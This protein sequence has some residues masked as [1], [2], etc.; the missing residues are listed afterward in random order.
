MVKSLHTEE[1]NHGPAQLFQMTGFGRLG[2]PS[3]G[4]W[5]VYGLGTENS[6]LP[7]FVVMNTGRVAG[8][9]RALWGSGFL[10]GK[11]RERRVLQAEGD[12]VLVS[13][14]DPARGSPA[15]IAGELSIPSII[16]I[17]RAWPTSATLKSPRASSSMSWRFACRRR[18]PI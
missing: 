18:S 16:S 8:A 10:P 15:M 17:G 1:I 13:L 7:A 9:G 4:A 14:S 2:R 11:H 6:D 5:A 3:M 12:P